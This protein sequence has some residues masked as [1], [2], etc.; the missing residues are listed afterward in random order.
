[1]DDVKTHYCFPTMVTEFSYHSDD[2][3]KKQMISYIK[4]A[5]KNDDGS[6]GFT[7]HTNDNLHNLS[8]FAKLRN[9]VLEANKNYA[10]KMN[11]IYDKIEITG[12]WGNCSEIGNVHPPHS[13]S[14]N[15][16]SGVYYLK[17]KE[18]SAIH[19]FDPRPQAD[20]LKPRTSELNK[21]NSSMTAFHPKEGTGYIF[22]SWL[23][24]WVP[25]TK[26]E[27]ISISWNI[28]LRGDYGMPGTLQNA[29]I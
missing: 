6:S 29:N 20:I 25:P 1:M 7:V 22:P 9:A 28:I 17:G 23:E 15:L 2:W 27:R 11:F 3:D 16:L 26:N 4:N 19:F 5:E 10:E 8:Y 18:T 12:M 13:H 14:N 21:E 24:H